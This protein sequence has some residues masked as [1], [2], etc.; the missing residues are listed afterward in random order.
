MNNVDKQNGNVKYSDAEHVYWDD[1]GNYIS[2]TTLIGHYC[3]PFDKEFWSSY[4]ALEKLRDDAGI[5]IEDSTLNE[6][7]ENYIYNTTN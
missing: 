5:K 2:V 4:K 1:E 7:Y 6:Q 3:Q